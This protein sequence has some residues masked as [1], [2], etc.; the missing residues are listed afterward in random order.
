MAKKK[1]KKKR[2]MRKAKPAPEPAPLATT[3]HAQCS[4]IESGCTWIED[5]SVDL[6]CFSPPYFDVDG[7][8]PTMFAA[9]GKLLHRVL[10]PGARAFCVVGQVSE[11]FG[12]V[13]DMRTNILDGAK[14]AGGYLHTWQT[15]AWVKSVAIDDV[16]RGHYQPIN[17]KN[18]LNYGW[19]LIFHFSKGLPEQVEALDRLSI[20]VPYADKTNLDRGTRGKNGDL[21]CA[22]DVWFVPYD[23]TGSTK[24]KAHRHSYPAE[25]VE[26]I[27]KVSN[28]DPGSTVFDPFIGG[29]TTADVARA[30]GHHVIANDAD[31]ANIKALIDGWPGIERGKVERKPAPKP[32]KTSKKLAARRRKRVA[33][34]DGFA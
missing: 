8:T 25:L 9:L 3:L 24:K 4:T 17:S 6:A 26:R 28:L 10:K 1:L 19:E 30:F 33:A 13:F 5:E 29:G 2:P 12:R 15:I 14:R 22:G 7:A 11:D 32:T 31:E 27:I 23:T 21:H 20:G 34:T 16:Q 18:I